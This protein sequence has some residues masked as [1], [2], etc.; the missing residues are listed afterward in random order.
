MT[1]D[2]PAVPPGHA[3][4]SMLDRRSS[5]V[6]GLLHRLL[7]RAHGFVQI[8]NDALARTARFRYAVTAIAQPVVGNL[9]HQRAGLGTAYVDC[10]QKVLVLVRHSYWGSPLAIAGLGFV[11]LTAASDFSAGF[12]C[13]FAAEA[14]PGF[15]FALPL[16]GPLARR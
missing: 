13:V 5:R 15:A 10:G 9:R 4:Q 2:A 11:V 6:F 12:G 16:I 14:V 7:N 1:V 8:N 3:Q